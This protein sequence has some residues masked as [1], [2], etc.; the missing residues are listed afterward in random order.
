MALEVVAVPRGE[1][2]LE[3]G[4]GVVVRFARD[5]RLLRDKAGRPTY[6]ELGAR[7]HYS[8]AS[9]SE[10]AGG[11]KLPTLSVTVAYVTACGG[12]TAEWATR[13]RAVAAELAAATAE[14]FG[15]GD[16]GQAPYLGL[17]AFEREDA[18]RF[19]GRG[20]LVADLVKRVNRYRFLG[21]FGPSGC[22]KSSVLRAGL[23]AHLTAGREE[24]DA[25][26]VVFTPGERPFEEC[27]VHLAPLL[28]EA[29][30]TLRDEFSEDPRN[31]HLR[32][33]QAVA[34]TGAES[35][36]VLIVDQFEE[37]FALCGDES[38]Q[39]R[40]IDALVTAATD[41]A[42]RTRVVL[43]VRADFL[44]H[45]GR[46][47]RLVSALYD[48]QVLV[49]PMNPD[50]LRQAIV[51]PAEQ[52]GYRLETALVARLAG[53]ATRQAGTL[54]LVSHALLQTWLR[55]QGTLMTVA[56]YEAVGGI[57]HALAR[58][59]EETYQALGTGQQHIARQIFL[60]LTALGE[61]TEDTKRRIT[62]DELDLDDPD[63]V[64]VLDTLVRARLI[65]LGDNSVE[66][67]HEA[68]IRHWPRLRTWLADDRDGHRIHRR[69]TEAAAEWDRHERDA[70]L[71][72]RGARLETWEGRSIGRLNDLERTFLTTSRDAAERDRRARRRR[73]RFTV[74]GLSSATVIV[75][76]IAVVALV[77]AAR[78]DDQRKLA[79]SRQLVT[80]ARAQLRLDPELG[81][82]L[83]REAYRT[84]PSEDTEAV[85]RQ[86]TTDSHIRTTLGRAGAFGAAFS[87]DGKYVLTSDADGALRVRTWD[88][89]HGVGATTQTLRV[90]TSLL[91]NPVF[92][93][94]GRRIAVVGGEGLWVWDWGQVLAG[95]AQP[96]LLRRSIDSVSRRSKI[97][98]SSDGRRVAS[99]NDDGT[100]RIWNAAGDDRPT[101]LG[102]HDGQ[103][104]GVAFSRDGKWLAGGGEDGTIRLWNLADGGSPVVLRGHEGAVDAVAFSPDGLHL[105]SAGA[106][107]TVRVWALARTADAV[108]VLGRHDGG[109][110]DVAY[111]PDG[112]SVAGAGN[113][114]TVKIWNADLAAEPLM[115]RGHRGAVQSAAFS[116]DGRFILSVGADLI[117]VKIWEVDEVGDATVLRGQHGRSVSVAASQDG[118][119]VVSGGQDGTVRLWDVSGGHAPIVL[120][121]TTKPV[122]HVAISPTGRQVA[123]V[124]EDNTVT[125]WKTG[126]PAVPTRLREPAPGN[127][128]V[129]V[130]F[131]ADG[132][133]LAGLMWRG[134]PC[135]WNTPESSSAQPVPEVLVGAAPDVPLSGWWSPDGHHFAT[136]SDRSILLWDLDVRGSVTALPLGD[137][138]LQTLAFSRDGARLA[139][140]G[141]DGT[142]HIWN[143][144]DTAGRAD[145]VTLHGRHQDAVR[146][147]AFSQDGRQLA[148]VGIDTTVRIWKTTGTSEPLVLIGFRPAPTTVVS[149]PDGR[150][151]TAH[152]DGTVRIWRCLACG[153]I[154]EVLA[155]ANR[156]VT[157]ELTAE[158]RQMFLP[159]SR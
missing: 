155:Q 34:E 8:A 57:E 157:R 62:P 35:D 38:Q 2:P 71:L 32:I 143:I 109:A 37:L 30:G 110:L 113:D 69:L 159:S 144:A 85:L 10:A 6:R 36:V 150:Y 56:G 107:G 21:V 51:G 44:E 126:E 16:Q 94:D 33:R 42:S 78:A 81:L 104:F 117:E 121:G 103:V 19:F 137:V 23:A 39:S 63:T 65:T 43:V 112:H 59:A 119:M 145:P 105:A 55:R 79:V 120:A 3:G 118:R 68:L 96:V 70:G 149:L 139:G 41:P 128:V 15:T 130:A 11:R 26:V 66:I 40:F 72:Y 97:A 99:G 116:P 158:E 24:D 60:R 152:D 49:G 27:A 93:S 122:L 91:W 52:A 4:D 146:S 82:L 54:P 131:S 95:G 86:A 14:P 28:G 129:R 153:P 111:S 47:H 74:G 7:A 87:P 154:T 20:E 88:T 17:A 133:R 127:L 84:A 125:I 13:W 114:G 53:D 58:T 142:I 115:L 108:V 9:L 76:V 73:I 148:T 92:S 1:R 124:Y 89:E 48:A 50:E 77:M 147:V 75:A 12:D 31:L 61:D 101:V 29:P 98:L 106:D 156:H 67:A 141:D 102:G 123:A 45:C 80:D 100:V 138:P 135:I 132:N 46:H 140:G 25:P 134:T 83:A 136:G 151:V 22:G 5:L 18:D 90:G 64:A